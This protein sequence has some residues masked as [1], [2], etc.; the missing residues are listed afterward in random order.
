[1]LSLIHIQEPYDLSK[2]LSH[3][4][5]SQRKTDDNKRLKEQTD[6]FEAYFLKQV[7][8]IAMKNESGLLP[9]DAGDKI[10][11]SMYNDTMSSALSGGLGL[12]QILFDFLQESH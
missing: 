5:V 6:Q 2:P 11:Q 10:Y 9:K 12:S 3:D 4:N 7:L 1:M 8:D